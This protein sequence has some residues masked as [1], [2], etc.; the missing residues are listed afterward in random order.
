MSCQKEETAKFKTCQLR[1]FSLRNGKKK[2]I[3]IN[4]PS[5][6]DLWDTIMPINECTLETQKKRSDRG[7]KIFEEIMVRNFQNLMENMNLHTRETQR[8][9]ICRNLKRST[10]RHTIIRQGRREN[11]RSSKREMIS[12]TQGP[13]KNMNS[14]FLIPNHV[15]QKAVG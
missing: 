5:V 15:S 6:R 1:L 4:G 13:L 12:Y 3:K 14:K 11:P 7:R 9:P 8:I 2:R 10:Q